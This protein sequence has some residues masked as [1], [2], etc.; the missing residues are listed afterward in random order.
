MG[1]R[2]AEVKM[3]KPESSRAQSIEIFLAGKGFT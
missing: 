2:F 1:E 3:V